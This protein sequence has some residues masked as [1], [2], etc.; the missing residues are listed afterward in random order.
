MNRRQSALIVTPM[1]SAGKLIAVDGARLHTQEVGRAVGRTLLFLHG[2]AGSLEDW[3]AIIGHFDRYRCVL[4]DSRGHGASTRTDEPLRYPRLAADAEAVIRSLQLDAPVIVG[5]SDGGIT[6]LHVAARG[7]VA[8]SGIVTIAAHGEPPRA[9]IMRDIYGPLTAEKWRA[10]F[11]DMVATYEK[12]NPDAEFD[13]FFAWLSA[14]WR[15]TEPGNYPSQAARDIACPALILGGDRD[16]LVPR[17]ETVALA[18]RIAGAALGI[19]PMGSH[20]PHWDDPATIARWI[21]A[22]LKT[23]EEGHR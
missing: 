20:V 22:F 11:P 18:G 16:H 14:M 17:A 21:A 13:A 3:D 7:K 9:D 4:M 12:L 15:D 2:G 6:A 19:V 23:V 10:R 8:L 1:H 5:H